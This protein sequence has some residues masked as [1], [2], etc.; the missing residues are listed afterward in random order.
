MGS[1]S[2]RNI[3]KEAFTEVPSLW[4]LLKVCRGTEFR[5]APFRRKPTRAEA[6][7]DG[8]LQNIW[9]RSSF[10]FIIERASYTSRASQTRSGKSE[11]CKLMDCAS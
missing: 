10:P 2:K 9:P 5:V 8:L 4:L 11:N 6:S 7:K 1:F 3:E